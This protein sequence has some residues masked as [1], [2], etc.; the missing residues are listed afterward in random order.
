MKK[1]NYNI[2]IEVS[3]LET[4]VFNGISKRFFKL[5]SEIIP[6][7]MDLLEFP[8]KYF[9][10]EEYISLVN[11]LKDNGFIIN[12]NVNELEILRKLFMTYKESPIYSL[13]ILS[14]YSCNFSCWYCIQRHKNNYLSEPTI[15]KIKKHIYKYLSENNINSFQVS[16]FGGEP[17]LNFDAIRNICNFAQKLCDKKGISYSS[18]ITTN[19]SL[20]T[21]DMAIE[22]KELGF[23][24]FQITIDGTKDDHN[25]T[26]YNAVIQDSHSLIL[27]NIKLL[28]A[29]I[30]NVQITVR[31]NYTQK[32][33][34][35]IIVGQIDSE[36]NSVRNKVEFVIPKSLAGIRIF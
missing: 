16:W 35:D 6:Q 30:P 18:G 19:G 23:N 25:K 11:K 7:L 29:T 17:L 20:I 21:P 24:D 5:S 34:S 31:F 14:T 9:H 15:K 36:L 28:A 1:S 12:D 4:L 2:F 32:N 8:D 10:Q 26:R 3:P 22:M 27:K 33:L 13:M